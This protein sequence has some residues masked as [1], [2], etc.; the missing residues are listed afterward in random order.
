MRIGLGNSSGCLLRRLRTDLYEIPRTS[1]SCFRVS[2]AV[3]L[4][5][6]FMDSG[7]QDICSFLV[8]PTGLPRSAIDS[9]FFIHLLDDEPSDKSAYMKRVFLDIIAE[10]LLLFFRKR[11]PDTQIFFL[12]SRNLS[13]HDSK[14]ADNFLFCQLLL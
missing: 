11:N 8:D 14:L 13:I 7:T 4:E 2:N 6:G 12:K 5:K 1:A 9:L 3:I 10:F